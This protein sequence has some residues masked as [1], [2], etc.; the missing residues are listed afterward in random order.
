MRY[1]GVPEKCV[2]ALVM[3]VVQNDTLYYVNNGKM[4]EC[5]SYICPIGD[6]K[7]CTVIADS[8]DVAMEYINDIVGKECEITQWIPE[9]LHAKLAAKK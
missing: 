2:C 3:T 4:K 5:K 8:V 7:L 9:N 1:K 6:H